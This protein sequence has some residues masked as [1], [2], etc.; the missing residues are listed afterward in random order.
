MHA[1]I[2]PTKKLL[3]AASI[4]R[5]IDRD[6]RTCKKWIEGMGIQPAAVMGDGT[7][8]FDP[9]VL[10]TLRGVA[11]IADAR[12]AMGIPAPVVADAQMIDTS[13]KGIC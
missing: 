5:A 13:P 4:A 10:E 11:Q 9:S 7:R 12:I 1:S 8:L 3:T 6:P 2:I